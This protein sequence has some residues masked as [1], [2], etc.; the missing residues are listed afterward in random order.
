MTPAE[1]LVSHP[2]TSFAD[3]RSAA[4]RL[5]A[6]GGAPGEVFLFLKVRF[7]K[8]EQQRDVPIDPEVGTALDEY[9]RTYRIRSDPTALFTTPQGRMYC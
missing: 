2:P 9:V 7:A 5:G 8:G 1:G 6:N 4:R 3:F